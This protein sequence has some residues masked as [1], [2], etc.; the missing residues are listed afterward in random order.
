[1][2]S[3]TT[4]QEQI[5]YNRK[6]TKILIGILASVTFIL[7]LLSVGSAN[8]YNEQITIAK[9]DQEHTEQARDGWMESYKSLEQGKDSEKNKVKDN[10]QSCR[11]STSDTE[12]LTEDEKYYLYWDSYMYKICDQTDPE[13]PYFNE[14]YESRMQNGYK[15]VI[16]LYGYQ[17]FVADLQE[18]TL[19]YIDFEDFPDKEN[20]SDGGSVGIAIFGPREYNVD[21]FSPNGDKLIFSAG[22]CHDCMTLLKDYVLNL[23]TLE[24]TTLGRS[25]WP[26]NDTLKWVDN[27]TVTW[28]E[29]DFRE[30][31]EEERTDQAGYQIVIENLG[32]RT[33]TVY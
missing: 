23:K 9:L 31:T 6:K 13:H 16:T 17:M 30:P 18:K 25:N 27:N 4:P 10:K 32:Q 5:G 28:E 15:L 29:I 7:L 22:D 24:I 14:F 11:P 19:D 33:K 12:Y 8:Y 21:H 20:Y 3:E 26:N 1:M 2:N